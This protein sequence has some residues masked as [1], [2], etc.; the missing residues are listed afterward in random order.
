M[1]IEK[2]NDRQIRCTLNKKDLQDR[3]IG[4]SEL[5]YG[6]AKA[7]ALFRDMMQQASYEFGFD[8]DDIPL[9]IEAIPLLPEALIL[10]VTKIDEPDELDTRFSSF[11]EEQDWDD[12][13]E[14]FDYD[15]YDLFD[16]DGEGDTLLEEK[17][18]EDMLWDFIEDDSEV[19]KNTDFISLPEVLGMEPKPKQ[20]DVETETNRDVIFIFAFPDLDTVSQVAELLTPIYRGE[21]TLYKD[22]KE[23]TFYLLLSRRG[24]T[25]D[26]FGKICNLLHEYGSVVKKQA[27][28]VSYFEEHFKL[29]I[30]KNALKKL[31]AL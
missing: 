24:H 4:I 10:V 26:N 16:M 30:A 20:S 1:H 29:I 21:N 8:A 19:Y 15:D 23:G 13:D 2:I 3:E 28:T 6:T 18:D 22:T 5:A 9:M 12:F 17:S 14:E 31:A 11:T 25:A 27:S 7:K